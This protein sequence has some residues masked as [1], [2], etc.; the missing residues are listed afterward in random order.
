MAISPTPQ[1]DLHV[2]GRP[3]RRSEGPE[4]TTGRGKYGLDASLPGMVWLKFL[5]SPFAHARILSVDTSAARRLAGVHEVLTGRD[6]KGVLTGGTYKD[7]PAL[8]WDTVRFIGDRVAAVAADDED[9]AEQA[10]ALIEIKYEELPAVVSAAEAAAPG[11]PV[12]HP[13]YDSYIGVTPRPDASRP[14]VYAQLV[15]EKGNVQQ[16]FGEADVVLERTYHTQWSHQTYLEPHTSLLDIDDDGKVQVWVSSQSPLRNREELARLMGLGPTDIT[17]NPSFVGG[18]FGGKIT[19]AEL[20]VSYTIAKRIGRP[21]KFAMDY[22]EELMAAEPRH[23]SSLRIKAGVKRDGTLTAWESEVYF[24]SGGYAAHAPTPPLYIIGIREIAGPY[25]IPHV[26]TDAFQVYTNTTPCGFARAPGEY[27][28]I[29][30]GESHLDELA[31]A[32]GMDPFDIRLKNIV[33]EGDA[34]PEGEVYQDIRLEETLRAAADASGYH[35]PKPA[36]VGRGIGIG[37]RSQGGGDAHV[38]LKVHADGR[39]TAGV[40]SFDPGP[41][42]FT[43]VAQAVAEELSVSAERVEVSTYSS[44]EGAFDFGVGAS[45][46]ARVWSAAGYEAGKEAKGQLRRLA[47]ELMGWSEEAITMEGGH[48]VNGSDGRVKIE[49]IVGR[50]G[51]EPLSV[52]GDVQEQ[53]GSPYTSFGVHVAEVEVDPDTGVVEL[54]NYT[55]AHET[56]RMLNPVGFHGQIEGGIIYGIGESLMSELIVDESGRVSNAS[57]ADFKIPTERDIPPLKTVV[58]ESDS[59][60]G[61]YAVRGIGEHTNIMVA[62]AIANAV[63]DAID[64]RIDSVPI[65]AEKVLTE[66]RENQAR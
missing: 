41:G 6:L 59:G 2:I 60:H 33:R 51:D 19:A 25:I 43:I 31:K 15:R 52:N 64:T 54:T 58:L 28:G 47:A 7:E 29:F 65:T 9:T 1:S 8:A 46:G 55:A 12:L 35:T 13:E 40:S 16:G 45:R 63:A 44:A 56:G 26:R 18:S 61:P 57:M 49:E 22:T 66:V 11:A 39:I 37:H 5:R 20:P 24:A 42:T 53:F 32:I 34:V 21:V 50:A 62:A 30:A 36:N 48:L 23:P 27:Q 10:A 17:I 38:M 3:A 14:N 4:K